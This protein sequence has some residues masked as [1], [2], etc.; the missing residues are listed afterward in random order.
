MITAALVASRILLTELHWTDACPELTH[1]EDST[2]LLL[3]THWPNLRG[4][5]DYT[6]WLTDW[7]ISLLPSLYR[8]RPAQRKHPSYCWLPCNTTIPGWRAYLWKYSLHSF[9]FHSIFIKPNMYIVVIQFILTCPISCTMIYSDEIN[10]IKS[11]SNDK[12]VA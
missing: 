10:Q 12:S 7:Q 8:T 1:F 3:V 6:D 2:E 9:H 11:N 4:L 5:A